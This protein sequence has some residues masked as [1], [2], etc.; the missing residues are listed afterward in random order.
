MTFAECSLSN[1]PKSLA[2]WQR[3]STS[4]CSNSFCRHSSVRHCIEFD[5]AGAV[6]ELCLD[7]VG[8]FA[9]DFGVP[10]VFV[11]LTRRS[12]LITVSLVSA[13][14]MVFQFLFYWIDLHLD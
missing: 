10:G 12:R 13:I 7:L 5:G 4:K 1:W 2:I 11:S 6:S 3:L 9:S 8:D 14:S